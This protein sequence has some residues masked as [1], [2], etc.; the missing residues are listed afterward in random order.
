MIIK[1]ML[2]KSERNEKHVR[3]VDNHGVSYRFSSIQ[4]AERTVIGLGY[5]IAYE[6]SA[7]V[8]GKVALYTK[9]EREV[10]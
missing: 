9:Y 7:Q 8:Y 1:T 2:L 4:D 10:R 6:E 3:L 5:T